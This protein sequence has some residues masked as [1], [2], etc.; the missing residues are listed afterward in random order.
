MLFP[1]IDKQSGC[2][3]EY[4]AE[5]SRGSID[6]RLENQYQMKGLREGE[7]DPEGMGTVPYK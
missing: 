5:K 2:T 4:E 7:T 3:K 6:E 1:Q